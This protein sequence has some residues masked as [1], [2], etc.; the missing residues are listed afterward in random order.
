MN[1]KE[2]AHSIVKEVNTIWGNASIF[3]RDDQRCVD[4]VKELYDEWT[5]SQK[6]HQS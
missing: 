2:S 4:K 6:K 3:T 5:A 1:F